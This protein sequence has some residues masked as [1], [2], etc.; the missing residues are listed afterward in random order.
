MRDKTKN[1]ISVILVLII[2]LTVFMSMPISAG[3]IKEA[4][5]DAAEYDLTREISDHTEDPYNELKG[6]YIAFSLFNNID[7]EMNETGIEH[8]YITAVSFAFC[9]SDYS[10]ADIT[11]RFRGEFYFDEEKESI[12]C[13]IEECGAINRYKIDSNGEY[14]LILD[15][16]ALAKRH[17]KEHITDAALV[18]IVFEGCPEDKPIKILIRSLKAYTDR[19]GI[20]TA[21]LPGDEDN[22]QEQA[23]EGDYKYLS[24]F[25]YMVIASVLVGLIFVFIGDSEGKIMLAVGLVV[26]TLL[27]FYAFTAFLISINLNSGK[28]G[29]YVSPSSYGSSYVINSG[30]DDYTEDPYNELE[31]NFAV[32]G[33]VDNAGE[34][35]ANAGVEYNYMTGLT[36]CIDISGYSDTNVPVKFRGEFNFDGESEPVFC[37]INEYEKINSYTIYSDGK[38]DFVFDLEALAKAQGKGHITDIKKAEVIF[39]GFPSE[40]QLEFKI[41]S[42]ELYDNNT[43]QAFEKLP[44][45]EP[46]KVALKKP[47]RE[48]GFEWWE[49]VILIIFSA[50]L[51]GSLYIFIKEK[52]YNFRKEMIESL[53]REHIL[54]CGSMALYVIILF[55][56][57]FYNPWE[58]AAYDRFI[59]SFANTPSPMVGILFSLFAP[60]ISD[61]LGLLFY[62][63]S[64]DTIIV[65]LCAVIFIGFEKLVEF[66]LEKKFGSFGS[67]IE[68]FFTSFF[69]SNVVFSVGAYI[70]FFIQSAAKDLIDSNNLVIIIILA[71]LAVV[72]L[73]SITILASYIF[74]FMITFVVSQ[75]IYNSGVPMLLV[76]LI[77]FASSVITNLICEKILKITFRLPL[78][79]PFL[80]ALGD[81]FEID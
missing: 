6:D 33:I 53:I 26:F 73:F 39:D 21:L 57:I 18:E 77:A 79:L 13:G 20:A 71:V 51:I 9:I 8:Q 36:F 59:A 28:S 55:I 81:F 32:Y 76:V 19:D 1:K 5:E 37:G 58:T 48:P 34:I 80:S 35:F 31:G 10:D 46:R 47:I 65:P 61:M 22:T 7:E 16:E 45:K 2:I 62:C 49:I 64:Q 56:G 66:I 67:F 78:S 25:G 17:G 50:I 15:L 70:F 42:I 14:E 63:F 12:F 69:M 74:L 27:S 44:G 11:A 23:A 24:V 41:V 52:T 68:S 29:M 40:K 60:G 30:L 3:M 75:I 43:V 38:Y 72:L 4:K 54:L